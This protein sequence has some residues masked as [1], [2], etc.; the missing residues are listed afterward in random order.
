[1]SDILAN[2]HASKLADQMI[3]Q[4]YRNNCAG[5]QVNI[6]DIDKVFKAGRAAISANP[7]IT[8]HELTKVVVDFVQTIRKN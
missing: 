4:I 7:K 3:D 8:G 5:V 1:M 2:K 6:M